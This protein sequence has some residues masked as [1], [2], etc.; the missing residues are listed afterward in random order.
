MSRYRG[1]AVRPV[2]I[3]VGLRIGQLGRR[4]ARGVNS[5]EGIPSAQLR[6]GRILVHQL[7]RTAFSMESNG[8]HGGSFA[9]CTS[10][11]SVPSS[12]CLML[13]R[14]LWVASRFAEYDRCR[15]YTFGS[16][17]PGAQPAHDR[18]A[19]LRLLGP[20]IESTSAASDSCHTSCATTTPRASI[21]L[22]VLQRFETCHRPWP[23]AARVSI[24]GSDIDMT[25]PDRTMNCWRLSAS[26]SR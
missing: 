18:D 13:L 9:D 2:A 21:T 8:F 6:L 4:N 12:S 17:G 14:S 20:V 15:P 16:A 25:R 26:V 24:K 3:P 22:S 7:L 11:L 19:T 23:Q 5:D 1:Q 10:I